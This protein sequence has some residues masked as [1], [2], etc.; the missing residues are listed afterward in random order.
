VEGKS[1]HVRHGMDRISCLGWFL[2]DQDERAAQRLLGND[3]PDLDGRVA[4]YVCP[5]CGDLLCGVI[6]AHIVRDA[7]DVT[8]N[9]LAYSYFDH[10]TGRWDHDRRP[11]EQWPELRFDAMAYESAIR[12]RPRPACRRN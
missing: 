12:G 3:P 4:I 7:D 11:F 2:P 5:E 6:S 1:L 8:W 9:D 10:D